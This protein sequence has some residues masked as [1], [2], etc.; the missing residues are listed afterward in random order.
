MIDGYG[1]MEVIAYDFV[2][3]FALWLS[4]LFVKNPIAKARGL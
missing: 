2:P 4:F 3:Q 1:I